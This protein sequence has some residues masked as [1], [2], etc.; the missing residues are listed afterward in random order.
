MIE[1]VENDVIIIISTTL[2]KGGEGG[3]IKIILDCFQIVYYDL[4]ISLNIFC[5]TF[6]CSM[7]IKGVLLLFE[8]SVS[9]R[10]YQ[11]NFSISSSSRICKQNIVIVLIQKVEKE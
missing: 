5:N 8:G 1:I 6:S 11:P 3:E 7:S 4:T 9:A 2:L 10:H